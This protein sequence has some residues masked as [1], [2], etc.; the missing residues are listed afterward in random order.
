MAIT[1]ARQDDTPSS[2]TYDI[3]GQ[4]D[5]SFARKMQEQNAIF[6][7]MHLGTP[8]RFAPGYAVW[9]P[10]D[11]H[12]M[13]TCAARLQMTY[14]DA[15]TP[16]ELGALSNAL[17]YGLTPDVILGAHEIVSR[18]NYNYLTLGA[19]MSDDAAEQA[20]YLDQ[21]AAFS[22]TTSHTAFDVRLRGAEYV[23]KKIEDLNKAVHEERILRRAHA[24]GK[25]V[26]SNEAIKAAR[27]KRINAM[28]AFQKVNK[29]FLTDKQTDYILKKSTGFWDSTIGR[30]HWSFSNVLD[31]YDLSMLG[32]TLK[33]VVRGVI[34]LDVG[35]SV[36]DVYENW[37]EGKDWEYEM[38]QDAVDM[39]VALG[40][41]SVTVLA[42][43][44][45]TAGGWVVCLIAGVAA[46]AGSWGFNDYFN[47]IMRKKLE[48]FI[49]RL[50]FG[51]I[52]V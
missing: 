16:N 10:Q 46:A 37:K 12:P 42:A 39:G 21:A 43:L 35:L 26:I 27:I 6:Q 50:S 8:G 51:K 48:P 47:P 4:P 3:L 28:Q 45:F 14:F 31:V 1:F 32:K 17:D 19:S 36:Y 22:L 13:G 23:H 44:S 2:V 40:I 33:Q 9:L 11:N 30:K 29:T 49:S 38:I 34:V 24:Q 5:E 20:N 25:S 7:C 52:H 41:G 15:L 18:L